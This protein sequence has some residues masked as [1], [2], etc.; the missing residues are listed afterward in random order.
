MTGLVLH[1]HGEATQRPL[2]LR[3]GL[4]LCAACTEDGG[5]AETTVAGWRRRF[6]LGWRCGGQW[7]RRSGKM[8]RTRL[9]VLPDSSPVVCKTTIVSVPKFKGVP[10]HARVCGSTRCQLLTV[11]PRRPIRHHLTWIRQALQAWTPAS[12]SKL[13]VDRRWLPVC[14][15]TLGRVVYTMRADR[16]V[17]VLH[18]LRPGC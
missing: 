3:S 4:P 11:S 17:Q 16:A 1:Y 8:G 10:G 12:R 6:W 5:G 18:S 15:Q 7:N 14:R 2:A 9:L 13:V